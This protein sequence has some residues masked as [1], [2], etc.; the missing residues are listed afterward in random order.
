VQEGL[1]ALGQGWWAQYGVSSLRPESLHEMVWKCCEDGQS[2]VGLLCSLTA[3]TQWCTSLSLS[4]VL[5]GVGLVTVLSCW[6]PPEA[7]QA[8]HALK[9]LLLSHA[10]PSCYYSIILVWFG[11]KRA[12]GA[13]V[14]P[15]ATANPSL[16]Y[17]GFSFPYSEVEVWPGCSPAHLPTLTPILGSLLAPVLMSVLILLWQESQ[18]TGPPPMPLPS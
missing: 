10:C 15:F 5:C 3:L 12:S 7:P 2:E 1:L 11:L 14:H 13:S 17:S 4:L 8:C 16:S 9:A 6:F 18:H